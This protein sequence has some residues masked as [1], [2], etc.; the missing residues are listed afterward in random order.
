METL[1]NSSDISSDLSDWSLE[2]DDC[3]NEELTIIN[4]D[5][6]PVVVEDSKV[7]DILV[8]STPELGAL[9]RKWLFDNLQPSYCKRVTWGESGNH[10]FNLR[11]KWETSVKTTMQLD[12]FGGAIEMSERQICREVLWLLSG[13]SQVTICEYQE[14]A[15]RFVPSDLICVS[16]LTRA[17]L[18]SCLIKICDAATILRKTSNFISRCVSC[19]DPAAITRTYSAFSYALSEF[20]NTFLMALAEME[21]KIVEQKEMVTL[22]R[23]LE[24]LEPWFQLISVL[25][26]IYSSGIEKCEDSWSPFMKCAHLLKVLFEAT[27]NVDHLKHYSPQKVEL[28]LCLFLKT[29]RPYLDIL[30]DWVSRGQLNDQYHEF[31]LSRNNVTLSEDFWDNCIS[32]RN[33]GTQSSA[34]V[35]PFFKSL[36]YPTLLIGKSVELLRSLFKADLIAHKSSTVSLFWAVIQDCCPVPQESE[37]IEDFIIDKK[38]RWRLEDEP[39]AFMRPYIRSTDFSE[40][41]AVHDRTN[42]LHRNGTNPEPQ[43]ERYIGEYVKLE[44]ASLIKHSF[45]NS[46][47]M[48]LVRKSSYVCER[49]FQVLKDNYNLMGYM[50]AVRKYF[51]FEDGETMFQFCT[52]IFNNV[53]KN[54]LRVN[55]VDLNLALEDILTLYA[56]DDVSRLSVH[57]IQDATSNCANEYEMLYLRY[58][59]EWPLNIILSVD[60]Q[61]SLDGAFELLLNL[62]RAL[63]RLTRLTFGEL[64]S[65]GEVEEGNT[66]EKVK[67]ALWV[68][69]RLIHLMLSIHD[70]FLMHILQDSGSLLEDVHK[71]TSDFQHILDGYDKYLQLIKERSLSTNSLSPVRKTIFEITQ[72]VEEFCN[73]WIE[74]INEFKLVSCYK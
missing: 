36:M 63:Y 38:G 29:V 52:Y 4:D 6:Q 62:K 27:A 22:M 40:H 42:S 48:N 53:P 20:F 72:I 33:C 11:L 41:F 65:G 12:P 8:P 51:L 25:E 56:P 15:G 39:F 64:W 9:A 1:C 3:V 49:L 73:Y 7:R 58:K 5:L 59:I 10:T 47:E 61:R 31:I 35:I 14:K 23:S 19:G 69:M 70:Y 54:G 67:A 21:R 57:L 2:E 68:R 13:R 66:Q 30:D 24:E 55:E 50:N 34:D 18:N 32:V 17:S 74:G 45:L 46:L 60:G 26:E 16:H 28:T 44:T 43:L 71:E 37:F